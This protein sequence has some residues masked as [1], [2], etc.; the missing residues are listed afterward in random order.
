MRLPRILISGPFVPDSFAPD[1]IKRTYVLSEQDSHHLTHVLRLGVGSQ[2]EVL[3]TESNVLSHAEIAQ[4]LPCTINILTSTRQEAEVSPVRTLFFALAKSDKNELVC[5][6]A[7]ELGL[8]NIVFWQSKRSVAKI[9]DEKSAAKK[10]DRWRKIA[11]SACKQCSRS[12]LPS[13]KFLPSIKEVVALSHE[14]AQD[15][16]SLFLCSLD[17]QAQEIS[18]FRRAP[19]SHIIVGPE[20]DFDPHEED[21]LLAGGF[22]RL[23]LGPL[24]LRCETAAIAGI[25]TIQGAWGWNQKNALS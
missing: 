6:K 24:I 1:T 21:A 20:G 25:C 23:S 8:S 7:T 16:S 13:I 5:E 15:G 14:L 9:E 10:L 22:Q 4:L 11:A 3:W 19:G 12:S 17:K 18:T 2:L